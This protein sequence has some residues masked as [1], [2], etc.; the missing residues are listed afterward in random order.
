LL[1]TA[2]AEGRIS[3]AC[4][5]N[6]SIAAIITMTTLRQNRDWA[7][8]RNLTPLNPCTKQDRP[9]P[10]LKQLGVGYFIAQDPVHGSHIPVARL[11]SYI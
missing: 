9:C 2:F 4:R 6:S 3:A 1:S 10:A 11:L 8:M 7:P 5:V